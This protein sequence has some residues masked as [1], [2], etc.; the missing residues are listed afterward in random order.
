[1]PGIARLLLALSL[2]C[3]VLTFAPARAAAPEWNAVRTHP[4]Q[5]G[6]E[7]SRLVVGFRATPA[8]AVVKAVQV[9]ARAQS[10]NIVQ[11]K[12]SDA[13][14]AGLALRTGLAMARSRQVTP[15]MHV[16]YLQKMVYGADVHALLKKLRA[17]PSV[18]F[19]D[20]DQRRYPHAAPDDP[21]FGPT[22]VASG[23]WFMQKPSANPLMFGG[24][25]TQ[26]LS[27]T[28]AISAWDIT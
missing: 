24:V 7:A 16:L 10:I 15:S 8:N 1:M 14:V 5:L 17:D 18:Q 27:A 21:L 26:D 25:Q 4:A 22:S 28:D 6:P 9:R 23:Q 2:S 3:T 20:V 11:A 13:D 12:T 19:A